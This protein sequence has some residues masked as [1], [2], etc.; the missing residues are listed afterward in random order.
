[1]TSLLGNI[2]ELVEKLDF[3]FPKLDFSF[4][5][6]TYYLMENISI[7][8]GLFLSLHYIELLTVSIQPPI[9]LKYF[10]ITLFLLSQH[11]SFKKI[12]SPNW[13]CM[14]GN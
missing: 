2:K 11:Y 8:C 12:T 6:R 10:L 13:R 9:Y 4:P 7:D 3:S 5:N 1:M 14:C